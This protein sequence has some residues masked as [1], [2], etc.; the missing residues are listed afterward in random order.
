MQV[1]KTAPAMVSI[2]EWIPPSTRDWATS[3]AMKNASIEIRVAWRSGSA[4]MLMAAHAEK[5][6]ARA[7]ATPVAAE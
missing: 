1:P 6:A 4:M 2:P 3:M 7:A 5:A